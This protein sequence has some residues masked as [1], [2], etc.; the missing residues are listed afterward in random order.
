MMLKRSEKFINF[1]IRK[2]PLITH[3]RN[4]LILPKST[5]SLRI[6]SD[7][8]LKYNFY[9]IIL[10]KLFELP[11]GRAFILCPMRCKPDRMG[12]SARIDIIFKPSP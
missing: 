10:K 9:G 4:M 6:C 11:A 12:I 1:V 3:E 8:G 2:Y 7:S 5:V